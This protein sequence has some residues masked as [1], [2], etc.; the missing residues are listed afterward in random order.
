MMVKTKNIIGNKYNKLT[1][2]GRADDYISP[3]GKR[4][5]MWI[6]NCDCG[7]KGIVIKGTK[8]KK[9]YTKSCGCLA[10][11]LLVDRSKKYNDYNLS[12]DY[13]IGFDVNGNEFY[14]DL[15][16]YDKIRDYCWYVNKN[17]RV[18]NRITNKNTNKTIWLHRLVMDIA[19]DCNIIID[20]IDRN[21]KNNRKYN[22]REANNQTN[23]FNMSIAKNNKSGFIGVYYNSKRNKWEAYITFNYKKRN[24]GSYDNKIDAIKT[25]L[26]AEIKYFGVDFAP[27][28]HLFNKYLG[29]KTV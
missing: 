4:E 28:R 9:G 22:L 17:N 26:R 16:D 15:E 29:D 11:K 7:N 21:P 13:G 12:G 25:R 8:L 10:I 1:V 27:Q 3:S 6:C 24:L 23:T 5:A 18:T 20:H 14:F 19:D 2:V